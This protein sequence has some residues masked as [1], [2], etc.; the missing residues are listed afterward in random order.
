[1][2]NPEQ[3][4]EESV[5]N[6]EL[7]LDLSI[8]TNRSQP[9]SGSQEIYSSSSAS[10]PRITERVNIQGFNRDNT[11]TWSEYYFHLPGSHLPTYEEH[12]QS[13][14]S[15]RSRRAG[16]MASAE[17][18][19]RSLPSFSQINQAL[20]QQTLSSNAN[21]QS[22]V[23]DNASSRHFSNL[24][25]PDI[26]MV[27]FQLNLPNMHQNCVLPSQQT[28][29][30]PTSNQNNCPPNLQANRQ[31]D[32]FQYYGSQYTSAVNQS[33]ST[34]PIHSQIPQNLPFNQQ[35]DEIHS[36]PSTSQPVPSDVSVLASNYYIYSKLSTYYVYLP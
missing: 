31:T 25:S 5:E 17:Q 11:T 23:R 4:N 28:F 19:V 7:P 32:N 13:Q 30:L 14:I 3:E 2:L 26:F 24:F 21:L 33:H 18:S 15:Q 9:P 27:P 29:N 34:Q 35:T 1:V 12:M 6:T 20:D 10:Q 16:N 8:A 22:A 36:T